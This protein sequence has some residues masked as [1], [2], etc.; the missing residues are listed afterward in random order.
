MSGMRIALTRLLGNAVLGRETHRSAFHQS[1]V[2]A[3]RTHGLATLEDK[4]R[5]R[6]TPLGEQRARQEVLYPTRAD[7]E[8][9]SAK[10][11]GGNRRLRSLLLQAAKDGAPY[12]EEV[13]RYMEAHRDSA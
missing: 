4:G 8:A 5:L 13:T 11:H 6:L 9:Q 7:L 3:L 12:P 10:V 2:R 1:T